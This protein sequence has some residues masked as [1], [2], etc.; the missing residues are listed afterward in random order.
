MLQPTSNVFNQQ[1]GQA[2]RYSVTS[3][4]QSLH[5]RVDRLP[6]ADSQCQVYHICR[7]YNTVHTARPC[8]RPWMCLL[9]TGKPTK[10]NRLP[11]EDS[12]HSYRRHS[13]RSGTRSTCRA[14]ESFVK[15]LS[16]PI[17]EKGGA[18]IWLKQ[19]EARWKQILHLIR[20]I[21]RIAHNGEARTQA[22][23]TAVLTSML[24]MGQLASS[25]RHKKKSSIVSTGKV[26]EKWQSVFATP[27]LRSFLLFGAS[28]A[29][30]HHSGPNGRTQAVLLFH[31]CRISPPPT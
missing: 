8:R 17:C 18:A 6:A 30:R 13:L 14:A 22:L 5:E 11:G 10:C 7:R 1:C 27:E 15:I 21:R 29:V 9:T 24:A 3:P 25:L 28:T 20:L 2:G 19:L 12:A 23:V 26:Y 16:I 31:P 4:L